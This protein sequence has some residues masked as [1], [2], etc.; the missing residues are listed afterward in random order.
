M[1]PANCPWARPQPTSSC[2]VEG[3]PSEPADPAAPEPPGRSKS[4]AAA[5]RAQD[6]G[7]YGGGPAAP[8]SPFHS[9]CHVERG[10]PSAD[11]QMMAHR[12]AAPLARLP[13]PPNAPRSSHPR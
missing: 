8:C 3:A 1:R 10:G 12:R 4:L 13:N 6:V 2:F 9:T 7:T 11:E 5:V